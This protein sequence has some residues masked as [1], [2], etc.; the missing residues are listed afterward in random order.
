MVCRHWE[1][2]VILMPAEDGR[3]RFKAEK[4]VTVDDISTC[5]T[6]V[7]DWGSRLAS[8]DFAFMLERL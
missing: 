7:I 2:Q 8:D 6:G 4:S 1:G 5:D 3:F